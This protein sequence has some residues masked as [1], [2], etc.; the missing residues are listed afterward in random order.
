[1]ATLLAGGGGEQRQQPAAAEDHLGVGDRPPGRLGDV[2]RGAGAAANKGNGWW[3]YRHG[4]K[5]PAV[6]SKAPAMSTRKTATLLVP[7]PAGSD[8]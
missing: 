2:L 5:S 7:S 1:M 6:P 3:G 4:V 8:H